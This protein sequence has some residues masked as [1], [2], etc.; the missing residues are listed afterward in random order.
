MPLRLDS[1][2]PGFAEAFT[3]L[4]EGRRE[5]DAD[6]SRD[7]AAI[8]ADV[9]ARGDVALADHTQRFDRHDLEATGWRVPASACEEALA[10]L[11]SE[12]RAALE[13]A[14]ERIRLYHAALVGAA[15]IGGTL[16]GVVQAD[17]F[18]SEFERRA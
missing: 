15:R 11:D 2:D 18:G 3:A 9:R 13:L 4:V 7:V 17:A 12:L 6:V 16:G 10:A 8:V 14:A 1:R 5:A